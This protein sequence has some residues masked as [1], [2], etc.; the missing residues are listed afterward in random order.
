MEQVK[1]KHGLP[2]LIPYEPNQFWEQI[3]KLIREEI[4]EFENGEAF[5]GLKGVPGLKHKPLYKVNDLCDLFRVSKPTVYDW[6]KTG[7]ITPYKIGT[8]TYF[9]WADVQKLLNPD[10]NATGY[11]AK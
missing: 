10:S 6:C 4:K 11:V 2:I 9:L 7:K 1:A 3:R 5:T 8:R